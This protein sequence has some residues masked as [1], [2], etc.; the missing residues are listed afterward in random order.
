[1]SGSKKKF[2]AGVVVGGNGFG[3]GIHHEGLDALLLERVRS[4]DT[5][6]IELNPLPY[7]IGAT[8]Q[9]HHL[10]DIRHTDLVIAAIIS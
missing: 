6:V 8:T 10:A 9:N 1:V 3:V 5:A 4:V 2:V 7:A